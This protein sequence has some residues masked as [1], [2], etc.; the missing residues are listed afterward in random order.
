MENKVRM[1]VRGALLLALAVV[2]QQLR[3]ILP[4]PTI[5][6]TLL[7]GTVVNAALVLAARFTGLFTAVA[8][9]LALPIIAFLQGQLPLVF[10]IPIVFVGN[11]VLVVLCN[12]WWCKSVLVIA[13]IAKTSAMYLGAVVLFKFFAVNTSMAKFI[14]IAMSWPQLL[15]AFLG[16]LLAKFLEKRLSL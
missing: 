5:I 16:I 8:M 7:I 9:C 11:F 14:L 2:V 1:L 10:L 4:L 15:T 3:L 13:P 12:K 6:T